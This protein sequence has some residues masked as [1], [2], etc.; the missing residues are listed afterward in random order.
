MSKF[1]SLIQLNKPVK[2]QRA[3]KVNFIVI[4]T[5]FVSTFDLTR[6][7]NFFINAGFDPS[8]EVSLVDILAAGFYCM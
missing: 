6:L 4:S 1:P 2:F 7:N 5:C 8:S 3:L